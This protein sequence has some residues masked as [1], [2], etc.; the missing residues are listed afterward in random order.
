MPPPA[1]CCSGISPPRCSR[2]ADLNSRKAGSSE[3]K[4]GTVFALLLFWTASAA[5]GWRIDPVPGS[6]AVTAIE[7]DGTTPRIAIGRDWYKLS[8]DA[9]TLQA[10][11]PPEQHA[12][13]A[14][15]LQDGRVVTGPGDVA[16]AWFAAPTTRYDHGVLGDAIEAGSLVIERR[17]GRR[18]ALTLEQDAVFEDLTPRIVK[19][20]GR[21]RIVVVKSYLTRGSALAVID[22]VRMRIVAE[23][24]P[25]GHPH[26]WLNPAGVA[27]YDGDGHSD[28]AFV[29]QPHAV[30][31][32]ELWSLQ[33]DKLTKTATVDDVANHFIGSRALGMS[34]SA[35][36][37]GDG[38]PDLAIPSFDRRAL[39]I[40]GFAPSIH[41]IASLKLPGR[42][43]TNIVGVPMA[44]KTALVLA[45]DNGQL[46]VASD[47]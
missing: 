15:A 41:D 23:T 39:R 27:D 37:D 18:A 30:G 35:D 11:S 21:E 2:K 45:L 40:I 8:G 9:R 47:Q 26:A 46:I 31:R 12:L 34:W 28:L 20:D 38:H 43:N 5:A 13:P 4:F 6:A 22:P 36:F 1:R 32:L 7:T 10:A 29:R 44:G 3:E 42:I 25:I 33:A 24:P 14:G 16:R 17:D 19:I